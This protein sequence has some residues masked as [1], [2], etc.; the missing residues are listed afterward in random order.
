MEPHLTGTGC[1]LP[2]GITQ[3]LPAT[4]HKWTHPAAAR[5]ASTQFT[6]PVGMEG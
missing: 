3:V 2:Y 5:L 1:H 6:Y 4:R